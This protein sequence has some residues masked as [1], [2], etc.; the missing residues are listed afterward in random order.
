MV[1]RPC[2][3]RGAAVAAPLSRGGG[4]A[5]G[6]RADRSR[7]PGDLTQL[8]VHLRVRRLALPNCSSIFMFVYLI[9][10]VKMKTVLCTMASLQCV[11]I[12]SVSDATTVVALRA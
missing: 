10:C 9:N 8:A 5:G 12:V 4:G 1:L 6:S 11:V 7:D 3:P 2:R